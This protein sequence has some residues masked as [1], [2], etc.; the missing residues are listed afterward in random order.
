MKQKKQKKQKKIKLKNIKKF[1][2]FKNKSEEEE[3][4]TGTSTPYFAQNYPSYLKNLKNHSK[5]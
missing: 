2:E 3:Y 4:Y 1:K 5:E